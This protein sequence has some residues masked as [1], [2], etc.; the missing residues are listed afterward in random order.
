M[1]GAV[2][3]EHVERRP[4]DHPGR[5]P[6]SPRC[7]ARPAHPADHPAPYRHRPQPQL[8]PAERDRAHPHLPPRR[9]PPLRA[10]R[11][12]DRRGDLRLLPLPGL[13]A[14]PQPGRRGPGAALPAGQRDRL[15]R[16]ELASQLRV[17]R[18]L[19]RGGLPHHRP[20]RGP[21]AGR[22][23]DRPGVRPGGGRAAPGA[24]A[25]RGVPGGH[26]LPGA[27]GRGPRPPDRAAQRAPP[28]R[29][30]HR[31][32]HVPAA[33]AAGPGRGRPRRPGLA[34]GA[35]ARGGHRPLPRAG[36]LRPRHRPHRRL[37]GRARGAGASRGAR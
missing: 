25:P 32:A 21:A 34:P 13:P 24:A 1:A 36:P 3:D 16:R 19:L 33:P 15:A 20:L 18:L 12:P 29:A 27:G 11:P 9:G 30:A 7:A 14:G 10:L 22:G 26:R 4:G 35:A 6:R 17:R 31:A 37:A 2:E 28:R 5:G 8:A 23:P